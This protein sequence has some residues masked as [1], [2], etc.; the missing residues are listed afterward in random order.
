MEGI[1]Y[2]F[3]KDPDEILGGIINETQHLS[4]MCRTF[5]WMLLQPFLNIKEI[6]KDLFYFSVTKPPVAR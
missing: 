3:V 5:L 4:P 1:Y 6:A 2:I